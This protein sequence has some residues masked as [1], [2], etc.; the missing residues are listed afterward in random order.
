MFSLSSGVLW[1]TVVSAHVPDRTAIG[2]DSGIMA[3]YAGFLKDS[4]PPVPTHPTVGSHIEW[5]HELVTELVSRHLV[6]TC[7]RVVSD[8]LPT[9]KPRFWPKNAL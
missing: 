5:T 4:I 7:Y 3:V 8:L 1:S 2:A 6:V 9:C